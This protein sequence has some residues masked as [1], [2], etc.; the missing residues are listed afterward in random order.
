MIAG[1]GVAAPDD[2]RWMPADLW[3]ERLGVQHRPK[4]WRKV[5]A[6]MQK[7]EK[8]TEEEQL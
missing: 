8:T 3:L 2:P 4:H 6:E 5:S 1:N 7:T